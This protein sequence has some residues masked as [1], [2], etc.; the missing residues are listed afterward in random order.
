MKD[1]LWSAHRSARG[2]AG[3]YYEDSRGSN[4]GYISD[5]HHEDPRQYRDYYEA[6]HQRS[7]DKATREDDYEGAN[8][9]PGDD[10]SAL[11]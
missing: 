4:G 7:G 9:K 11:V 5:R 6:L 8:F 10:F 2:R 3:D 1:R